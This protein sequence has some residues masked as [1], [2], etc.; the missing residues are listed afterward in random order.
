AAAGRR[1]IQQDA[2]E[3]RFAR[4]RFTD[5]AENLA[6]PDGE[7]DTVQR[8]CGSAPHALEAARLVTLGE[9]ARLEDHLRAHGARLVC[10]KQRAA[11]PAPLSPSSGRLASQGAK[12]W[13]QRGAKLQ[14]R[15]MPI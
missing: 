6:A 4:P 10:R 1:E 14:P 11:R 15:R 5:Q 12:R 3:R 13:A 7:A 8:R 2:A 9:V